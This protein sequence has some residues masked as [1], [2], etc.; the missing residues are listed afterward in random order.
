MTLHVAV[1]PNQRNAVERGYV[2]R[3]HG[4]GSLTNGA[5]WPQRALSACPGW[6]PL[7]DLF[8]AEVEAEA[9]ELVDEM[10]REHK[11]ERLPVYLRACRAELGSQRTTYD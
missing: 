6:V 3:L 9:D 8:V 1:G 2:A 7:G 5:P 10:V 4:M 11:Q